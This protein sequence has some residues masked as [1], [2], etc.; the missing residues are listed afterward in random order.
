MSSEEDQMKEELARR[1][2]EQATVDQKKTS[3]EFLEH[4]N[5][6]GEGDCEISKAKSKIETDAFLMGYLARDQI[7]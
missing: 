4:L 1:K 6:C 3:L 7:D 5:Q 2:A